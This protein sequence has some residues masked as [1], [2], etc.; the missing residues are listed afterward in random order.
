MTKVTPL[1]AFLRALDA[2]QRK[3]FATEVATTTV[4]LY[5]LAAQPWPN[6]KLR[7]SKLIVEASARYAAKAPFVR[8]LS[9]D[10]LLVGTSDQPPGYTGPD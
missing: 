4:Y 5:Q 6:P 8:P 9:Y 2:D 1:L 10:D 3:A 7:L